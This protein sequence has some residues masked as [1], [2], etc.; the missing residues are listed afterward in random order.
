MNNNILTIKIPKDLRDDIQ[1]ADL[2]STSLYNILNYI[3]LNDIN[4]SKERINKYQQDYQK[5]IQIFEEKKKQLENDYLFSKISNNKIIHWEL[6]Y[7]TSI[8]TIQI[9]E[10]I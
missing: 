3:T 10:E 7:I 8:V 6:N 4:I 5:K 1:R 2:E 9:V